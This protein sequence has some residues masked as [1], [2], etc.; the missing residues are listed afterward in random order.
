MEWRKP[1]SLLLLSSQNAFLDN[2]LGFPLAQLANLE[3]F[4]MV[5]HTGVLLQNLMAQAQCVG[6]Y[7]LSHTFLYLI[8]M[9]SL[10]SFAVHFASYVKSKVL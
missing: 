4:L 9:S 3:L 1:G 7:W 6:D 8:L 2:A 10:L 5:V